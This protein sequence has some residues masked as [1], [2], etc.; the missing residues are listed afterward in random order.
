MY[1][2]SDTTAR[3]ERRV[4]VYLYVLLRPYIYLYQMCQAFREVDYNRITPPSKLIR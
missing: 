4:Q 2:V 3:I 1:Y